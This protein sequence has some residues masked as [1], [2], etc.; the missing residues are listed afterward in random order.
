[1]TDS[2]TLRAPELLS[3]AG[4][5]DC[6]RAA[7]ENGADAVYF[8]TES[9]NAR[10]RA[11]NFRR[12]D[13]PELV[14]W[15]HGRGVRGYLAFNTLAFPSELEEAESFLR[16]A[17]ASGIDA[18][19]VQDAGICRLIRSVSPDFPIHGSTQMTVASPAGIRLARVRIAE[20]P[21]LYAD[22]ASSMRI[23]L[24]LRERP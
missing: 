13:L 18:A 6:A 7:V 15:L 22:A 12:K 3:P 11:D 23:A 20:D 16:E 2:K 21:T 8:G 1:M 24:S 17:I 9:F 10:M 19:I 4:G 14:R 5:W